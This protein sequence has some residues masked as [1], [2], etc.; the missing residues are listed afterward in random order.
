MC[1]CMYLQDLHSQAAWSSVYN[2]ERSHPFFS[3]HLEIACSVLKH[4]NGKKE[5]MEKRGMDRWRVRDAAECIHQTLMK[6]DI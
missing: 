6:Q 3:L 4:P 5:K 1:S 2:N